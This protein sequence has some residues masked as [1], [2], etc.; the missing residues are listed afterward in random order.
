MTKATWGGKV[1]F[2]SHF[3][4]TFTRNTTLREVG[5]GPEAETT[6]YQAVYCLTL[7]VVLSRLSYIAQACLLRDGATHNDQGPP[8]SV[9]H[10]SIEV[11]P[12]KVTL[13]CVKVT[14][15]NKHRPFRFSDK[16]SRGLPL[17]RV[18]QIV[19]QIPQV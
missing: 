8:T 1:L 11:Q 16:C 7:W 17:C 2:G 10:S 4:I 14:R 5:A 15:S 6:E 3:Q 19:S 13:S 9:S 18:T 12:F